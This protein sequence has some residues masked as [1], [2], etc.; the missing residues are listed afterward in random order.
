MLVLV[1]DLI[2]RPRNREENTVNHSTQGWDIGRFDNIDWVPWDA[3]DNARAKVLAVAD[4]FHVALV[5]A[6]A[7]YRG[8]VHEHAHPEFV[9]VVDG[10]L[11]TQGHTM[12]AGDAYAATAGSTHTDFTVDSGATYLLVFKL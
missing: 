10:E 7:G 8:G 5:E 2:S 4:G 6:G 12:T 3:G 11:R 9:Y 1:R